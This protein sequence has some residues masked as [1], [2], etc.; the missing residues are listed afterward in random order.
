MISAVNHQP[1]ASLANRN[2]CGCS[3]K[4]AA[5]AVPQESFTF[6]GAD[7][8]V[9]LSDVLSATA[10]EAASLEGK[11]SDHVPGELIV[12]LRPDMGALESMNDFAQD[13]G[14][15][16]I[17]KFDIPQNMFK[18]FDGEMVH[19]KLPAGMTTAQAIAAMEKDERVKYAATNDVLH[20]IGIAEGDDEGGNEPAPLNEQLWGMNNAG[21]T[22]GTADADID[23]PEAWQIQTGKGAAQNGPL[24]AVIDTG[25]DYNHP[26]LA[27]NVWTNPNEVADGVD[28]DGN[29]I[30]DDIHGY[31]APANSGDPMDDNAHGTHCSGTIAGNGQDNGLY[32][33]NHNA[34]LMGVKFLSA[35]GGGT[36][37]DAIKGVM[38]ATEQGARITSNSWGGGGFNQALYDAL[39]ASPALHIFAAG[40]ESNDDDR[41][42]TFPSA[43]DLNNIVS[44]AATD[45]NDNLARFSNYGATTVDLAAPGVDILSSTPGGN[46]SSFSGT[47][48]ATPHVAGAAGLLVSQFPDISNEELKARLMNGVDKKS[49]LEGRMITGGRLNINNSLEEDNIAPGAPNDFR[50]ISAA[51]GN[52]VLGWTATGDDHWCGDANGYVLKMSDRPIV[53]GEAGN[54]NEVSF[55]AARN[56]ATGSPQT[57]GQ[58]ENQGISVPLS[59]QDKTYY[60]AVKVQDNVGN[61]S[62]IRT[63]AVTVPAATVAFEDT[64]D[65]DGANWSTEGTWGQV[66]VEGR[67]KVFADSPDGDYGNDANS[68]L[69]TR[70]IDLSTLQSSTLVFDRKFDLEARYD[71]VHVEIAE[72]VPPAEGEEPAEP[73]F[74]NL[75]TFTGASGD[76][77]SEQI[78]V[79][80]YDGKNVQVRFRLESDGSVTRDGFMLDNVVIAGDRAPQ[81]PPT[82]G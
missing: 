73:V 13:Y 17:E 65:N 82:E 22:G 66:E 25:I 77:G 78:D 38:Y 20:A 15:A 53:D 5:P 4:E 2:A 62:E 55:D 60:F 56:I 57:T 45:H 6:A 51:P 39:E 23:A 21:Q 41:R 35:S 81:E 71:K 14:A 58:I 31:N 67:G 3:K 49:Q 72:I 10:K 48:M 70:T 75:T 36:L 50:A 64:L 19:I 46:Y 80:A 40:N 32:G 9:N 79:S 54:E 43:F 68:S 26:A 74:S 44:V 16:V 28:N 37:A 61:L 29:G 30:V 24:I 7:V 8:E 42:A 1:I 11:L 52:V 47:S 34:Q 12:K 33:V 27:G 59:G 76:W 69:T 18:A 63:T